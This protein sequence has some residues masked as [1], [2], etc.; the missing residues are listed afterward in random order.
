MRTRLRDLLIVDDFGLD[1][2]PSTP[3]RAVTFIVERHRAGSMI[4]SSNRGP[5]EW[6]ATFADPVRAQA[7]TSQSGCSGC[8]LDLRV[9][10]LRDEVPPNSRD[11][12][13]IHDRVPG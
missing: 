10:P 11:E 12:E 6:L 8:G 2:L 5:Y 9:R 7:V 1:A 4:R 3:R 13:G